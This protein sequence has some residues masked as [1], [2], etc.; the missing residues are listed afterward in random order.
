M[1]VQGLICK[2]SLGRITIALL[3]L[4]LSGCVPA[5]DKDPVSAAHRTIDDRLIGDW[6]SRVGEKFGI[7]RKEEGYEVTA[8]FKEDTFIFLATSGRVAGL[9]LITI[10][11]SSAIRSRGSEGPGEIVNQRQGIFLTFLFEFR[12]D[13]ELGVTMLDMQLIQD[14]IEVGEI[15]GTVDDSCYGIDE[16]VS[17]GGESERDI[18]I[19]P[20]I[21]AGFWCPKINLNPD[22]MEDILLSEKKGLFSIDDTSYLDRGQA[23]KN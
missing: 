13:D 6:T 23:I 3:S 15:D 5:L 2:F 12:S 18:I 8:E 21:S 1:S 17:D 7:A 9:D 16:P 11:L 22:V 4:L 10:D 19:L 14:K 20:A